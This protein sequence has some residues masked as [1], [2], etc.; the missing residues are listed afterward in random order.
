MIK[1]TSTAEKIWIK[2][3]IDFEQVPA[4]KC[5]EVPALILVLNWKKYHE[6]PLFGK[7]CLVMISSKL[8]IVR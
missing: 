2:K 7:L 4:I 3:L 8:F 1:A 5:Y 6:N